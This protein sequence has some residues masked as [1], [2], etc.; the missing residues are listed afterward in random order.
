MTRRRSIAAWLCAARPKTLT[1]ALAPVAVGTACAHA[2]GGFA[3]L[4]ALAAAAGAVLIQIG[5]N[6]VNDAADFERGA[7]T[8]DR[9]GPPRAA[10]R[11]LLEVTALWRG[12]A[13][14]FALAFAIGVYLVARGGWPIA[15]IGLA[16]IAAGYAYTA[17]PSPLAYNGLADLAVMIFF[18]AVA[19]CGTA[20]VQLGEVPSTAWWAWLPV[21]S[22]A[23]AMLAINNLRDRRG[24]RRAGKR[25]LAVRLGRRG[26]VVECVALFAIA[27]ATPIAAALIARAPL[28]ALP[29][30]T[31]PL[32]APPLRSITGGDEGAALNRSLGQTARVLGAHSAL[33][34]I[35][36]AGA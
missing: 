23:T 22:L 25:T 14:C 2:A 10:Q 28:L 20:L 11:G 26:A 33:W 13:L 19:V 1:A 29:L 34:A 4:A 17:G 18:G 31:A 16:S 6:L 35:G 7:D 36:I 15:A 3:A 30:L 32:A 24:D 27:Y 12:A 21:G 8:E 9:L 5:T